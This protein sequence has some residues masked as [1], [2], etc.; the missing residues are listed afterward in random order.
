MGKWG[1]KGGGGSEG[2]KAAN[3][4]LANLICWVSENEAGMNV[5]NHEGKRLTYCHVV[6]LMGGW[7]TGLCTF[8]GK[9]VVYLWSLVDLATSCSLLV[10]IGSQA[11]EVHT[12]KGTCWSTCNLKI[13]WGLVDWMKYVLKGTIL[14]WRHLQFTADVWRLL[15]L[16]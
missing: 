14:Q 16:W 6:G 10:W 2:E 12:N 9:C 11:S 7:F 8:R 15:M 1:R 3:F 13:S 4:R 5:W